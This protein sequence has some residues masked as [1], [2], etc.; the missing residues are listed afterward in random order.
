MVLYS[1]KLEFPYMIKDLAG[2]AHSYCLFPYSALL[3]ANP[4]HSLIFTAG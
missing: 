4:Y 1:T 3:L 2:I